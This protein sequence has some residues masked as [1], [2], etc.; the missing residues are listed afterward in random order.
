MKL[1]IFRF[2]LYEN[3]SQMNSVENMGEFYIWHRRA[4]KQGKLTHIRINPLLHGKHKYMWIILKD[5]KY[6][7]VQNVLGFKEQGRTPRTP[8]G[9]WIC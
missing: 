6:T 5:I 2:I 8:Q 4:G 1:D 3:G 7:Y 9:P